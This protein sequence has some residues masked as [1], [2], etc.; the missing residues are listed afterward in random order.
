MEE[1]VFGIHTIFCLWISFILVKYGYNYT[2]YFL[3]WYFLAFIVSPLMNPHVSFQ[4]MRKWKFHPTTFEEQHIRALLSFC[5]SQFSVTSTAEIIK[6]IYTSIYQLL[7]HFIVPAELY[8]LLEFM[9]LDVL[10][11]SMMSFSRAYSSKL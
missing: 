9:T 4:M 6:R 2:G 5:L 11:L 3:G 7:L 10:C 8:Q 1:S